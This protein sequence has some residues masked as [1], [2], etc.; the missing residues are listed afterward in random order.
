LLV[1]VCAYD[2]VFASVPYS[3]DRLGERIEITR[4][5]DTEL[6]AG[7]EPGHS[8]SPTFRVVRQGKT[9]SSFTVEEMYSGNTWIA[10][11]PGGDRF[12]LTYSDESIGGDVRVFQ[13]NGDVVTDVPNATQKATADFKSRHY[14]QARGNTVRALKWIKGD[15]LLTTGVYPTG[16]CGSDARHIEAYRVSV[17]DGTI[18][19][20]LTLAQLKRYPGLCFQN[21][22][23]N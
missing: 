15:L 13:M 1:S 8:E 3:E 16:D 21:D 17:P 9:I 5:G 6:Q 10:V 7:Y 12:A 20:H 18:K 2:G 23:G 4:I 14:C 19:Q 11:D 22:D